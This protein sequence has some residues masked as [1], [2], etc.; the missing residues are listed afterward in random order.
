MKL[1]IENL[2]SLIKEAVEEQK[3]TMLLES[4]Q[5]IE[6]EDLEEAS[7]R[8]NPHPF[9]AIF[10]FGP[11]G[12]GKSFLSKQLGI[13]KEFKVSNPDERIESV[14]PAFGLSLKF[15]AENQD[16]ELFKVQ[17]TAR[18]ILQN[19][20]QGH[21]ANLLNIANPLVFDTTGENVAKMSKRIEALTKAGYDVA[22]FQVNVP[23]ETSVARDIARK[24]TVGEPTKA[25]SQQYQQ[26]VAQDRGYFKKFES[27]PR[28]TMLGDD[29]YANIFDLRDGSLLVEPEVAGAM[30]T[31]DGKPFTA[32]YAKD[33][34]AKAKSDLQ[35]FLSQRE[36]TNPTGAALYDGMMELV[37]ASGGKLGQ[38]IGDFAVAASDEKLMSNPKI[39]KAAEIVASLGGAKAALAKAQRGRKVAGKEFG[40]AADKDATFGSLGL[41]EEELSEQVKEIIRSILLNKGR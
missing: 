2:K 37:S 5:V 1:S 24:R 16:E 10:I 15:A 29:I 41:R 27:N 26:Q 9:K 33:L 39:A 40:K 32:D 35:G 3:K 23:T 30:K 13:P 22:I 8:K 18:E 20:S 7:I 6:E 38:G 19:A 14:F 36:P 12:A 4:P 21:T 25:I 31:K 17:Q 34:L 28:V 11:A